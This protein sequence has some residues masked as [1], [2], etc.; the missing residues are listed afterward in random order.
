MRDESFVEDIIPQLLEIFDRFKSVN[1][2]LEQEFTFMI[3]TR[4]RFCSSLTNILPPQAKNE[5]EEENLLS[6][7]SLSEE[8]VIILYQW[9][10]QG[11][12]VNFVLFL[13]IPG[14][15]IIFC[16]FFVLPFSW[17]V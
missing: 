11:L 17:W 9:A 16:V 3:T 1:I 13:Y 8:D 7:Y 2:E 12:E 5:T 6:M 4:N 15:K 14:S 10:S